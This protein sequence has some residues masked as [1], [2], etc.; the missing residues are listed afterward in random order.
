MLRNIFLQ[1][2]VQLVAMNI[3]ELYSYK[4]KLFCFRPGQFLRATGGRYT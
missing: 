1:L 2:F 4:V 3:V